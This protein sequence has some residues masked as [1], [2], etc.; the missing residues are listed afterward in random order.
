[1][2]MCEVMLVAAI[3]F[4]PSV[5]PV[6]G[7][8]TLA[9]NPA[10]GSAP[11][12]WVTFNAEGPP[13]WHGQ[14]GFHSSLWELSRFSGGHEEQ[15]VRPD[16]KRVGGRDI[17]ITDEMKKDVRR[18]LGET[19]EK[20]GTLIV[21]LGYTWSEQKGCEPGDFE[22]LLGHVRD[23][24]T[25]ISD[26]PDVVVAVEAGVAGPWGEMHSSMYCKKEF[27]N[28]ILGMYLAALPPQIGLLV[29]APGYLENMDYNPRLG[30]YND[31]YLGTWWDYGTW[32]GKHTREW[33]VENL[34][35]RDD[36]PYGGE[37]AYVPR[38][39]LD[40]RRYRFRELFDP[41]KWNIVK[42]WYSVHL[43][44]LRNLGEPNHTIAKFLREE[45]VFDSKKWAFA[46]MPS[47]S[48]YDGE[49]MGKFL[50][51][52]MGYRFV[53]RKVGGLKLEGSVAKL[54]MEIENTGF[55]KLL[56]PCESEVVIGGK[57]VAANL[58]LSLKGGERRWIDLSFPA[59]ALP[60]EESDLALRVIVGGMPIRFS[61]RGM[62][63]ESARANALGRVKR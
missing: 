27:M 59:S 52:H 44:Y 20:H 23:L 51:D 42:D 17:P 40:G 38:E 61:N 56:A 29:R 49:K 22:I 54:A 25:I 62:W 34:K 16:P 1:M 31:G 10:R 9:G 15:G 13:N 47:L 33:S 46:G 18:F 30:M 24:S 48:E 36:L 11:G 50:L 43:A 7:C 3:A 2:G 39:F 63:N 32:S 14:G 53:V 19:R 12:G 5:D 6:D 60:S 45:L 28:R 41:E 58:D 55:G 8:E 35:G 37:L 21:R 26:F 57:P 4:A